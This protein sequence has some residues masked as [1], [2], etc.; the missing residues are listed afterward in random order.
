MCRLSKDINPVMI[1]KG[2]RY[3]LDLA[4]DTVLLVQQ[5]YE[6]EELENEDKLNQALALLVRNRFKVWLLNDFERAQLLEEITRV[7]ISAK[8]RTRASSHQ[9]LMDFHY[10]DAYIYASFRQAY[11]I[12]LIEER[13]KLPWRKYIDLLDGLPDK[14]KLKEVMRIRAMEIPT[15]TRTN[16][17]E[18]QNII[19]LKSYY[20]LPV[21]GGG[22]Q[23]GLNLLFNTLEKGAK[24][25]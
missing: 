5:L 1:F 8:K 13:G 9:K 4:Y 20:A 24:R 11:G 12:D 6:E 23:D 21:K 14:T 15:P 19:E 7:H 17:K 18:I 16:Q 3:R 2:K 22:G 25:I 10:D